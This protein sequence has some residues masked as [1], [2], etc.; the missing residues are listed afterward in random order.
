MTSLSQASQSFSPNKRNW[1]HQERLFLL[2]WYVS[3]EQI[4]TLKHNIDSDRTKK[5][6]NNN[7]KKKF[8]Q[9]NLMKYCRKHKYHT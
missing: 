7:N 8:N 1:I 5:N 6:H 4:E 3:G 2:G 9:N